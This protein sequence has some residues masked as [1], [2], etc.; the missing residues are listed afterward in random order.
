MEHLNPGF[1]QL[2]LLA[3]AFGAL[4]LWWLS[5]TLP[6]RDLRRARSAGE[7]RRSLERIWADHP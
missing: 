7:F 3:L 2:G 5:S 4:Q 6:G 1:L